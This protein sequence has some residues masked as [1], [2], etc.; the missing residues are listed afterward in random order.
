MFEH[1]D[2]FKF[3]PRHAK[4]PAQAVVVLVAVVVAV[5]AAAVVIVV[6]MVH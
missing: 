5:V 4:L 3:D 2:G 1:L 6:E